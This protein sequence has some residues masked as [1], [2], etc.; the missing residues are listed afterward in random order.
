[1]EEAQARVRSSK[2]SL[3]PDESGAKKESYQRAANQDDV[4][5]RNGEKNEEVKTIQ[6]SA[7]LPG[8]LVKHHR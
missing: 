3:N 2:P 7:N 5:A 4:K 8:G 6:R 1:M